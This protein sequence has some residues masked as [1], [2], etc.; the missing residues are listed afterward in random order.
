MAIVGFAATWGPLPW[1]VC[2]EIYPIQYRATGMALA[3]ASNW[4]FNFLIGF[5]TPFITNSIGFKYGYIFAAAMLAGVAFV[6][7]FVH[8]TARRSLEVIDS[9]ILSGVKPQKSSKW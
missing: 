5:C 4:I 8:E 2:A 7:F 9:M 6:Y 3:T 1:V